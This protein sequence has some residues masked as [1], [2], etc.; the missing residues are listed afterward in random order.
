MELMGAIRASKSSSALDAAGDRLAVRD[1]GHQ[2][3]DGQLEEA[4]LE[5]AAKEPVKNADL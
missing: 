3:V 2:R 1:E 5:T 4:R